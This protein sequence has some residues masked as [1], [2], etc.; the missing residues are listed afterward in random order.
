MIPA[1]A[2]L[3]VIGGL[4]VDRFDDGSSAP[5]G[6]VLH[7]TRALAPRGLRVAVLTV[8]GPEP[9]ARAGL[10]ELQRLAVRVECADASATATFLHHQTE[11]GRHLALAAAGGRIELPAILPLPAA[12]VLLTPIADELAGADLTHLGGGSTR[13]A[14]LQGWLRDIDSE[15]AVQPR[16]VGSIG[17]GLLATLAGF[18]LLVASRED[19]AAD[20]S[21]PAEQINAL[22]HATGLGPVLVLTDGIAGAWIDAGGERTHLPVPRVLEGAPTVGA[23]DILAALLLTGGWPRPVTAAEVRSRVQAAMRAVADLLTER[24]AQA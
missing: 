1:R 14:I 9:I 24:L 17:P 15:G 23:G 19:L 8:A 10:E 3:L 5:G 18:D 6:S 12:A 7:I 22:R 13:G 20:G 16:A 4:T 2:D 11:A 21:R